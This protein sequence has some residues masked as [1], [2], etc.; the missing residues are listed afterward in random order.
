MIVPVSDLFHGQKCRAVLYQP[1][2][3]SAPD[4]C[5]KTLHGEELGGRFGIRT[6]GHRD[7]GRPPTL[8]AEVQ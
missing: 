3:R 6:G 1:P 5:G 2:R 7:A 4:G 8:A